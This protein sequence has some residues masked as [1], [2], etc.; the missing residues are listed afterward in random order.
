MNKTVMKQ[1]FLLAAGLG[2]RLRPLT[3][4]VPKCMVPINGVPLLA[5]WL[6]FLKQ[7][8]FERVLINT[9]YLPQ[10]VRA[11]VKDNNFGLSVE[12]VHEETLQGTAGSLRSNLNWFQEGPSLIAHADN[13]VWFDYKAALEEHKNNVCHHSA[14]ATSLSFISDAPQTAGIMQL[15]ENRKVMTFHEKVSNPPGDLANGAVYFFEPQVWPIVESLTQDAPDIS[16]DLVPK[17][18]GRLFASE[19]ASYL[20]DIGSPESYEQAQQ[21]AWLHQGFRSLRQS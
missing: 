6:R 1:A 14:I 18:M 8:A 12:L 10:S 13:L 20:R 9:H 21:E 3:D 4:T 11:L 2:T 19:P 17:L 5:L 16:L 7:Q 15:D